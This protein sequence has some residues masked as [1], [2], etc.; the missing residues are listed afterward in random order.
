MMPSENSPFTYNVTVKQVQVST[1][2]MVK[3]GHR[4]A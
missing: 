1:D 2:M 4:Q 3:Y